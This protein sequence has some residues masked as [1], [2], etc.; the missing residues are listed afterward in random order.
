MLFLNGCS[1]SKSVTTGSTVEAGNTSALN[2]VNVDRF[3]KLNR[4]IFIM[5]AG[6]DKYLFKPVAKGYKKITPEL[7]DTSITNFFLNLG[8]IKNAANNLL[9][10]KPGE[11]LI[12]TERFLF[13]STIGVAGLFDVA[14]KLGMQKHTEDFGQTLAVWGVKPGPYIMLPLF[15]PSTLRDATA[16][17]TLDSIM[18]PIN[19][20]DEELA[21]FTLE[22]L[23]KRADLLSTEEAFKDLSDDQYIALRD[24]WLQRRESLILD[25]KVNQEEKS[26][27]IDELEDLD[28][29]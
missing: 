5:N 11:A 14:T 8:D 26:N 22:K 18:N 13:N 15:G 23:D 21:L 12:D 9:Q 16:K 29:D 25:G 27:L 24:A 10:F 17:L 3:E 20:S 2:K 1:H 7:V 4:R 6:I 19:Y 28:D